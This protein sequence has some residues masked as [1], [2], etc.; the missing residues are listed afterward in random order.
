MARIPA[1]AETKETKFIP[2]RFSEVAPIVLHE[3]GRIEKR[4]GP[5]FDQS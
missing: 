5:L 1:T 3:I 2:D 4:G